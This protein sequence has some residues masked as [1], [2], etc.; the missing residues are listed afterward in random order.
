[1]KIPIFRLN[2]SKSFIKNYN[3]LSKKIFLS[4]SISDGDVTRK[5]EIMFARKNESKYALAVNSCTSA[6]EI[7]FRAINIKNKEVIIPTNTFFGTAIP[8][9]RAGGRIGLCDN[10]KD[11]PEI[12]FE[13]IK[14]KITIYTIAICIV[15]VGGIIYSRIRELVKLCKTKRIFLIEDSAHAHFS[16]IYGVSAGNFG[17][18]GCFSFFPTKVMTTGEGGMIVTS[19]LNLY[20]KMNSIKNFGRS[21]NPLILN[22]DGSNFKISEFS[23]ALGILE[24]SRVDSRIRKRTILN[25]IYIN[26]LRNNK[27]FEVLRQKSGKCSNYKCIVKSKIQSNIIEKKL[28]KSGISLTGMV[29]QAPI[30]TQKLDYL[31]SKNNFKNCDHFSKFH[32]CLPNYPELSIKEAI[33]ICNLLNKYFS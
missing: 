29:W 14:K 2:F 31:R 19:N 26:K 30:H 33:S 24:L 32:F 20:R 25:N 13:D 10:E 12:S 8:I 7:A 4:K 22:N 15:H 23:S 21:K 11:S 16:N 3:F 5:F 18:I 27:N 9:N 6:L 17:D 1:M 28:K